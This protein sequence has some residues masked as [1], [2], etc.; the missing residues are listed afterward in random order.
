VERVSINAVTWTNIYFKFEFVRIFQDFYTHIRRLDVN[1][2]MGY[3]FRV[4]EKIL[5]GLLKLG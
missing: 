3:D 2:L 5:K 4:N 1:S